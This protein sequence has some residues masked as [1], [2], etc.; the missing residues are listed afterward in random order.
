MVIPTAIT[1]TDS[2]TK[3]TSTVEV[4]GMNGYA[5]GDFKSLNVTVTSTN[6]FIW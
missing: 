4:T 1:F 3:D 2:K 5:L 6:G